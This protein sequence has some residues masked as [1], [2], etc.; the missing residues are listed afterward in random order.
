MIELPVTKAK[1]NTDVLKSLLIISHVK[2]GK[3]SN[4]LQI[5]DSLLIDIGDSAEYYGGTY[6]NIRSLCQKE[7]KGPITILK[8]IVKCHQYN[9]ETFVE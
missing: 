2:C 6:L 4:C 7:G 5:P 9:N 1:P 8:E 3:T